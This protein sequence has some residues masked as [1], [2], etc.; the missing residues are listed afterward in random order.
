MHSVC[1]SSVIVVIL[2][3]AKTVEY[4]IYHQ[5]TNGT[6]A[7]ITAARIRRLDEIGMIWDPQRAIWN[8]MFLKLQHFVAAFGHCKVPK[9]YTADLELANWVRNQR[10]EY[11]NQLKGKNSR[12]TRERLELLNAVGFTWSTAMPLKSKQAK[13]LLTHGVVPP[14]CVANPGELQQHLMPSNGGS[15]NGNEPPTNGDAESE[16]VVGL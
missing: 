7:K 9:G 14:S 3:V 10:L 2:N 5:S 12:M 1:P 4:W 13:R 11:A 16:A 6:R 15:S 8:A